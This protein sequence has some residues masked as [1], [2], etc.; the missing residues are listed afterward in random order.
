MRCERQLEILPDASAIARFAAGVF[1]ESAKQAVA[2]RGKFTV[3]LSGGST[4]KALYSL[5]ATDP[6]LRSQVPWGETFFFFGDERCVPPDHADSNYRMAHDAMLSKAGVKP[7]RVFRMKG[8]LR[9]PELAAA[10]YE[11]DLRRFFFLERGQLP[12]FDL[13]LLGMGPDGHTASLFPATRALHPY[14]R[15][16]AANWIGKLFTHRLT[17]TIPVINYAASVMFLVHG[18]DKAAALK[19]VLEG[20]YEPAQLPAQYIR[21]QSG[22]V[23]WLADESA[24]AMLDRAAH[25]RGATS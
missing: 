1:I 4:P 7:E 8:E 10:G 3:V 13:I 6:E 20:P 11:Q 23:L 16:I 21:P 2:S 14:S 9:D 22:N 15:L 18:Q 25:S 12:R 17:M 5:L 24:A 19:G